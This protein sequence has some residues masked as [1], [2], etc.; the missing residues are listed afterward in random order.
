MFTQLVRHLVL[1][2]EAPG[3][4]ALILR[5]PKKVLLV[6]QSVL[7]W[8]APSSMLPRRDSIAWKLPGIVVGLAKNLGEAHYTMMMIKRCLTVLTLMACCAALSYAQS[9]PPDGG[10]GGHAPARSQLETSNSFTLTGSSCM[11]VSTSP[12]CGAFPA[13]VQEVFSFYNQSGTPFN[14]LSIT[15]NFTAADGGD[16]VGCQVSN[17]EPTWSSSNCTSGVPIPAGG[18][19]V[20][21]TFQEGTSGIGVSCFNTGSNPTDPVTSGNSSCITNSIQNAAADLGGA[22]LP[23]I[24]FTAPSNVQTSGPC[25]FPPPPLPGLPLS[26]LLVCGADSWILGIGLTAPAGTPEGTFGYGTFSDPPITADVTANFTPEPPTLLLVG[27]AMLG[28]SMLLMKKK[29]IHA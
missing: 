26:P 17:I 28:M 1:P 19:N 22:K 8:T 3:R 10:V 25:T 14:S 29:T 16:S 12:D 9:L 21:L 6:R 24:N 11:P 27:A 7:D 15:L 4:E 18:G 20:T 13:G 23:F 2:G 5:D